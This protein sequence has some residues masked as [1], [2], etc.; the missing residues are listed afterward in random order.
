MLSKSSAGDICKLS[1]ARFLPH[2]TFFRR[3]GQSNPELVFPTLY[4]SKSI[5]SLTK[6]PESVITPS[7]WKAA[8]ASNGHGVFARTT[9][10]PHQFLIFFCWQATLACAK[11][12]FFYKRV[13]K[14]HSYPLYH[15]RTCII[16]LGKKEEKRKKKS[17]Q[18]LSTFVLFPLGG[19]SRILARVYI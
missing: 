6:N 12:L 1:K 9:L 15:T 5:I 7:A 14:L 19:Y 17:P 8:G 16:L 3:Y 10:W 4:Q 11:F 13:R 18:Y 2:S